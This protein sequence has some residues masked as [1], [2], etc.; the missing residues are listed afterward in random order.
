V[1]RGNVSPENLPEIYPW[2]RYWQSWAGAVYLKAY[3]ERVLEDGAAPAEGDGLWFLLDCF[4]LEKA[5]YE[6]GYEL[7]NRRAWLRIPLTGI[8]QILGKE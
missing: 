2:A 5:I 7:N 6:I 4:V 3:L 8:L 1:E